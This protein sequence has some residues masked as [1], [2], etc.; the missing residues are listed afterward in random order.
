M[1]VSS[2]GY[3]CDDLYRK[4]VLP[5]LWATGSILEVLDFLGLIFLFGKTDVNST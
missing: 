5:V 1:L 2:P 3:E 4:P